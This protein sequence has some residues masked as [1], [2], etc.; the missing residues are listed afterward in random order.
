MNAYFKENNVEHQFVAPWVNL[1]F[2]I[3]PLCVLPSKHSSK[4]LQISVMGLQ[5]ENTELK[6]K[7]YTDKCSIDYH[8]FFMLHGAGAVDS[9][10]SH[11][12]LKCS[13]GD[14]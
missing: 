11:G 2:K 1:D 8:S 14:G 12:T 4:N 13:G 5:I 9:A 6:M 3:L 10:V 7:N